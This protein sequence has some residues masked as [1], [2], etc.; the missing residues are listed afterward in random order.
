MSIWTIIGIG[1]SCVIGM[2][3]FVEFAFWLFAQ[4][5]GIVD[6]FIHR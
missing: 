3:I 1:V 4:V 2:V 6:R 5:F